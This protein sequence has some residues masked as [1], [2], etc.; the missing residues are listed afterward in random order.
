MG[1][2]DSVLGA[3]KLASNFFSGGSGTKTNTSQSTVQNSKQTQVQNSSGSST[4]SRREFSDGF[5]TQLEAATAES[6]LAS[7]KNQNSLEAQMK[8]VQDAKLGDGYAVDLNF[9]PDAFVNQIVGSA[10]NAIQRN[11]TQSVNKLAGNTGGSA[12]GNS[13]AALLA[14]RVANEGAT[15]LAGVE[16]QARGQAAEIQ[17]ANEALRLD[18]KVQGNQQALQLLGSQTEQM[19]G[20]A[21]TVD[22]SLTALLNALK[23]GETAQDVTNSE[24]GTVSTDGTI[25]GTGS[26][27]SRTP[28]NWTAGLGNL[29]KD[30]GQA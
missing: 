22:A 6:L 3:A 24:T 27:T 29:F 17:R 23:G 20:I 25:T 30:I 2:L 18:G 9:N 21:S 26:S 15:T 14:S 28:F 7:N 5:L 19:T 1:I 8:K 10:Q 16:G 12:S 4:A 11:T 13:A